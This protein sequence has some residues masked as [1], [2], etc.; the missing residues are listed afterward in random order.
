MHVI[1]ANCGRCTPRGRPT[2]LL[3]SLGLLPERLQTRGAFGS[4]KPAANV[5]RA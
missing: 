3:A 2:A 5:V 4:R 1:P